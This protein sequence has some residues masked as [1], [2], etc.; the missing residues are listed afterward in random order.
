MNAMNKIVKRW[1]PLVSVIVMAPG[2]M[3][4]DRNHEF[5]RQEDISVVA[6]PVLQ[7]TDPTTN[8]TT[9]TGNTGTPTT[10][11][12]NVDNYT[13]VGTG[14]PIAIGS[15][16]A[17]ALPDCSGCDVTAIPVSSQGN[18]TIYSATSQLLILNT[19]SEGYQI[20]TLPNL[21]GQIL[22]CLLYTS[23]SPRDRQKSRM[24]SSA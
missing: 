22:S 6:Q 14:G 5:Q 7:G 11:T 9:G 15:Q 20:L 2:L 16:Y 4:C 12:G 8:P 10:G 23:P 21:S 13:I 18:S 3:N 1:I 24:P 17:V 19:Q